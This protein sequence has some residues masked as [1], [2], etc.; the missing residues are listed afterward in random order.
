MLPGLRGFWPMSS[1]D[2]AG[3]ANDL[4][5]QARTLTY[6]GNP[7]YNNRDFAPYIDFDGAGDMLSRTDEAALDILGTETYVITANRGITFGCWVNMD[8]QTGAAQYVMAKALTGQVAGVQYTIYMPLLGNTYIAQ[9]SSGAALETQTTAATTF[10]SWYHVIA[11][12]SPTGS[13]AT[14]AIFL[15]GVKSSAASA[16]AT[17]NN[18][19]ADFRIGARDTGAGGGAATEPMSGLVSLAFLCCYALP[20]TTIQSIWQQTRALFNK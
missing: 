11:R 3:N 14:R 5:G 15:D 9:F 19:A 13:G 2:S 6:G 12:W 18:T 16:L 8:R 10:G 1:F 17:L 4:S 20:D 7:I